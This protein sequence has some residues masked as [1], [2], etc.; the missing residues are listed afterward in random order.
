MAS[1]EERILKAIEDSEVGLT[2]VDV[3]KQAGISKT[4]AIKYLSVL[5]SEGK[6]EFVEVGPSKLW[7]SSEPKEAAI[8]PENVECLEDFEAALKKGNDLEMASFKLSVVAQL[9]EISDDVTISM[10]FKVKP[11]KVETFMNLMK[12]CVLQT[13]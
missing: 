12:K 1:Y 3:A 8:I 6:C 4:T 5:K 11:E 9:E 10:S 7:R 13:E 2:T